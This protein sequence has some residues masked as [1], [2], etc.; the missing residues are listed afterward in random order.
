MLFNASTQELRPS[1]LKAESSEKSI[2]LISNVFKFQHL[3]GL[4]AL[5]INLDNI[6]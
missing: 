1:K 3:K 5:F 4:K 2:E 6:I